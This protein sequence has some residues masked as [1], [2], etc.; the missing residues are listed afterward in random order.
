M[1][2]QVEAMAEHLHLKVR[3]DIWG[4]NA[5]ESLSPDEMHSIK[6]QGQNLNRQCIGKDIAFPPKSSII[7]NT[8]RDNTETLTW[9]V[10]KPT[11]IQGTRPAPGYPSLPDHGL[12][13]VLWDIMNVD[14]TIGNYSSLL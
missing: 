2:Y 12:K 11:T 8:L 6:Y 5:A 10:P 3:R 4:Y 7:H 9:G 14:K 1:I 13:D